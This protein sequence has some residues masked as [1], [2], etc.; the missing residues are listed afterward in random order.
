M[1]TGPTPRIPGL[2]APAVSHPAAMSMDLDEEPHAL[3]AL[4]DK[5]KALD[6]TA[7]Q[8]EVV[9]GLRAIIQSGV[10]GPPSPNH[11]SSTHSAAYR[12]TRKYPQRTRP[13][14]IGGTRTASR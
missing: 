11:L 7:R 2:G 9:E 10:W 1:P 6:R 12:S 14:E 13:M 3:V 4:L 5:V 8:A